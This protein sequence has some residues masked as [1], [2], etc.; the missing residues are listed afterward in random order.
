MEQDY[1]NIHAWVHDAAG[2]SLFKQPANSKSQLVVV[3]CCKSDD[4]TFFKRNECILLDTA[5][6][7]RSSCPY[8]KKQYTT[9]YTKRARKNYSWV[10]KYQEKYKDILGGLHSPTD[11]MAKV[12]EYIYL[13]YAH[14][15]MNKRLPLER[16]SSAFGSGDKF[17]KM[18][19]FTPDM[20]KIIV[21]FHPHAMMG[22]EILSYQREIVPIFVQHLKENFPAIYKEANEIAELDRYIKVFSHIG[23]LAYVH[24]LKTGCE[25]WKKDSPA[26][27]W[28]WDGEYLRSTTQTLSFPITRDY[29]QLEMTMLP[30]ETTTITITSNDQVCDMTK[31]LK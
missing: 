5:I 28:T 1:I 17:L 8:G 4:C 9:G 2:R 22:G 12:G 15:N 29:D 21:D 3:S 20:I 14:M 27:K 10:K 23:R 19:D 31:F 25:I 16:H 18:S 13:P 24:T 7:N 26:E 11:V 30:T 6:F